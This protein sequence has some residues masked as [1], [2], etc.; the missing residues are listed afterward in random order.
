MEL[1]ATV[2]LSIAWGLLYARHL[3]PL[4]LLLPSFGAS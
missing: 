2:I 4:T 3:N 1:F